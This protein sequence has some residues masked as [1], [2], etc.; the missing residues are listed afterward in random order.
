MHPRARMFVLGA[1]GALSAAA[2]VPQA[3]AQS[4][5]S[6]SE[7]QAAGRSLFYEG[8]QL[9]DQGKYAAACAKL[10]A[11]LALF[12]G[13]GT[14]GKLAECYEKIGRIARAWGLYQEILALAGQG[15][16]AQVAS[17]RAAA[18]EPRLSRLVVTV[19]AANG[20]NAEALVVKV[21]GE[22]MPRGQ[23]GSARL[24][25]SGEVL[26]EALAPGRKPWSTHARIAESS[27]VRVEVPPLEPESAPAAV[28]HAP[29]VDAP[30]ATPAS[31]AA[32]GAQSREGLGGLGWQRTA[33]I[34][35]GG[36]GLVTV[37]IG[38]YFGLSAKST[39]DGAFDSN[40][41]AQTYICNAA[42]QRDTESAHDQA[43]AATILFG[44]GAVLAAAGAVLFFTAP[45]R[46]K[47]TSTVGAL[48]VLPRID[49]GRTGEVGITVRTHSW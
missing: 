38:G 12:P 5:G 18:L 21:D 43:R 31:P 27:T 37:L 24:V 3:R 8:V 26:V 13:V 33:G 11:S 39:Y 4:Q 40:C 35:A 44:T 42:G 9:M 10:E 14:R 34:A 6:A 46:P 32:E 1:I 2:H 36:V 16:R 20:T 41:N 30:E 47:G 7:S 49:V 22:V 19:S 29:G 17:S 28:A 48:Q 45:R 15:T 23:I 25:D